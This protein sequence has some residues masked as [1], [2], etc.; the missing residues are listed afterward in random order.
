MATDDRELLLSRDPD[1]RALGEKMHR[2]GFGSYYD[3]PEKIPTIKSSEVPAAHWKDPV[4]D[5]TD[6]Y[7]IVGNWKVMSY[8][9]GI[10]AYVGDPVFNNTPDEASMTVGG[11][12]TI[13]SEYSFGIEYSVEASFFDMIKAS[14]TYSFSATWSESTTFSQSMTVTIR[15][16]WIAWI[17]VSPVARVLDGDFI[18]MRANKGSRTIGKFS[19]VVEAPGI[20]GNLKDIYT[21][22]SVPMTDALAEQLQALAGQAGSGVRHLDVGLAFPAGLLTDDLRERAERHEIDH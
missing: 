14:T 15:P 17:E 19:G 4:G 20:E 2:L 22:Q 16:G 6:G 21:L 10:P 7:G 18:Y 8:Y 1:K 11:S 13:G 3:F 12:R 9:R 5:N